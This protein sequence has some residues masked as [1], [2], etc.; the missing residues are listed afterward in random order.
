MIRTPTCGSAVDNQP[1]N[2]FR[3]PTHL[4]RRRTGAAECCRAGVTSAPMGLLTRPS[5]L[6]GA[7]LGRQGSRSVF[8]F[9]NRTDRLFHGRLAAMGIHVRLCT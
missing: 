7:C 1:R 8:D 9:E 4:N 3:V 2:S 5:R 6:C